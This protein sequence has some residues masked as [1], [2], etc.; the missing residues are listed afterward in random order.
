MKYRAAFRRLWAGGVCALALASISAVPARADDFPE[1]DG[2]VIIMRACN[3]CHGTE[4]ISHQ[5]KDEEGWQATVVRMQGKGASVSSA[6]ADTVVKYLAKSFPKIVDDTKVNINKADSKTIQTL[7]FTADE[8]DKIVDYRDRHGDFRDWHDLL[9]IYGV[10]G[11]K[12]EK[13]QDKITF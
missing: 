13:I 8:A 12:V 4:Q 11:E 7:G 3:V 5:R 2:K 9:Q 6:E 10:E 1:G